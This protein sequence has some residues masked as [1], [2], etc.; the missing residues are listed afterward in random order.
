MDK[1]Q[2]ILSDVV[3]FNKYAKFVPALGRRETWTEL[4]HRNLNMH[5]KKFPALKEDIIKIYEDFVLTKKVLPS[6]RS[7]QFAGVPIEISNSRIFNCAYMPMDHPFAFAELMFLLL[8]GTGVGYSVQKRHVKKLPIIQGPKNKQRRFLIGDSIEGWSDSIKVLIKAYTKGKSEPLFDFR[9]I[10][11]KGARLVT[12]GGKAPGPDPLRICLERIRSILTDSIGRK[13]NTL[14]VHDICCYIADAVLAGGIRR[15]AMICGFDMDDMDMLSCKSGTWYE[16]NP[17]RGRANNSVILKR[18]EVS[19][20]QFKHLWNIVKASGAG[21]PGFFWT[22]DYDVFCNPCVEISLNPHQFCNLNEINASDIHTQEELNARA[23]AASIIGTLQATYTDFHYLRPEWK[24]ATEKEALIGVS[25]TGIGSG[26]VLGLNLE[27]AAQ[28]VM[29]TNEEYAA[30][31]GISVAPRTCTVKPSGTSSCVVGSASGIHAWHNDYYVRR[32]RI[33]KNGALYNYMIEN[34]PELVED[35]IF[36]PHLEAVICIPQKAPEG[37]ILR[38]ESALDLCERVKKFNLEWVRAGH[39]EGKNFHNVSC[40]I[41]LKDE[42]WE[43]IGNWM[44]E[45]RDSYTGMSVLNFDGGSYRQT[46]F[47]DCTKEEY[48]NMMKYIKD[49]DLTQVKEVEDNTSLKEQVACSGG[50]CEIV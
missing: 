5:V 29:S 43:L 17:Q 46:P 44:W 39:K 1:S 42:D 40:T 25:M 9:D 16:L 22:D 11:P 10:R 36:K 47:T 21:E 34:L 3:V 14:E 13:L 19:E 2:R 32:M 48:E 26:A 37:A 41:S 49:I 7:M 8:G 35:C 31:L 38:T 12:S 33:G 6:M 20:E 24:E 28:I 18:G 30:K 4:C 27:E 23:R 15:A 50:S 45:N